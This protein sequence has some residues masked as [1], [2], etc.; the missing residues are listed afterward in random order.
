LQHEYVIRHVKEAR[1]EGRNFFIF[2]IDSFG[3]ELLTGLDLAEFIR[4]MKGVKTIAYIPEKAISAAALIALGCDEIVMHEDAKLGD[5]GIMLTDEKGQFHYVPEKE[6][7]FLI[8]SLE[9]LAKAKGYPPAL[10]KGMVQKE[11][12]VREVLDKKTGRVTFMSDDEMANRDMT[13]FE[14]R[15]IVK[16]KDTFLTVPGNV[17]VT[18]DL[19]KEQVDNLDGVKA[20]YGLDDKDLL[21]MTPTW[22]DTLIVVLNSPLMSVILIVG[23][24]LGLYTELKM[25]GVLLPGVIAGLC[26]LLFFWSHVMGGT[27]T[28]LEIVLF[29]AGVLCLGVEILLIPGFGVVGVTGI[30]LMI[31]SIILASQ[32]F[33]FPESPS[34]WKEFTFSMLPLIVAFLSLCVFATLVSKYLPHVPVLGRM[35]L[36]PDFSQADDGGVAVAGPCDELRGSEGVAMTM[37]RPAGLVRFGDQYIDVVSDGGYINEGARVQVI[38]VTGNRIVVKQVS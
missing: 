12:V 18:L 15:R 26:F 19:A 7:S 14:V 3:G 11:L 25:P 32:T 29:L 34:Q 27:A 17:A 6:L 31:S 21:V 30:L 1:E 23:G 13:G 2:E 22:V 37:L 24:I 20:I 5:C 16:D 36:Q 9:S 35:V 4:D 10:V 8:P 38:E 33:V 28:A